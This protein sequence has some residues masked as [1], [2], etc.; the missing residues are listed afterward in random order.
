MS[1]KDQLL[2]T[3]QKNKLRQQGTNSMRSLQLTGAKQSILSQYEKSI[4]APQDSAGYRGEGEA[5]SKFNL[6][7]ND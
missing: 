2:L 7:S 3:L 6:A 4:A 1:T 5:E